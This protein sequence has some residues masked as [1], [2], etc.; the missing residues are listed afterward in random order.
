MGCRAALSPP[1]FGYT[2]RLDT[3]DSEKGTCPLLE[4]FCGGSPRDL[5]DNTTE[6]S[7]A[8]WWHQR[9]LGVAVVL[10]AKRGAFPLFGE[11][12]MLHAHRRPER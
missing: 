6:P 12:S 7:K 2:D 11:A 8:L 9:S 1:G 3:T 10:M 4:R 5:V